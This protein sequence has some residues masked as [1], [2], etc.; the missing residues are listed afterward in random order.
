MTIENVKIKSTFLGRED[1]GILTCYLTLEGSGFGISVG[2][3]A[4]DWYD[5]IKG[6]R[7]PVQK[8]FKL[9][10][11]IMKVVGVSSWEE[12]TGKYIRIEHDGPGRRVTKIGHLMNNEWLDFEEFFKEGTDE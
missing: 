12:L 8:G 3:Y 5:E 9:I 2:G 7:I 1:H 11:R 10:D 6:I 4:L